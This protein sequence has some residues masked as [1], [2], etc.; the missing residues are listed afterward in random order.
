LD[1]YIDLLGRE[2][3]SRMFYVFHT[4]NL[5]TDSPQVSLI[6]PQRLARMTIEAGLADWVLRKVE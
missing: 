5:T 3:F 1:R 4:G 6:G 2:S